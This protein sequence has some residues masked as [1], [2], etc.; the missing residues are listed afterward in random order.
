MPF[1]FAYG[2]QDAYSGNDY[3]HASNS[4][5]NVVKGEYRVLLPDGRTQIVEYTADE[6]GFHPVVR[7]EGEAVEEEDS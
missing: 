4:D 1:D 6:D 7:Y 5:G 3:A 2:V